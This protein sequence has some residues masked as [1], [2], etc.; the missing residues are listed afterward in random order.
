MKRFIKLL[1]VI[2][3]SLPTLVLAVPP[4][5]LVTH[6]NTDYESNAFIDGNIPSQHPTRAHADN[7]V[8]WAAV[9]MACFGHIVNGRCSALIKIATNTSTPLDIGMLAMDL[10]T[11]DITPKVISANGFT[12]TV[13]GPAETTITQ[14]QP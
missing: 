2:T 8:Y 7:K 10:N 6:N 4:K 3:L 12:I 13:N 11:G 5:Q 1:T 9:K 14:D